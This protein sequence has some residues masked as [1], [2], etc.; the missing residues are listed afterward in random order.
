MLAKLSRFIRFG[1]ISPG[2]GIV[3][4]LVIDGF[5]QLIFHTIGLKTQ[6]RQIKTRE[7][8]LS[9]VGR[10]V[11]FYATNEELPHQIFN[12]ASVHST[13]QD[14]SSNKTQI[15]KQNVFR[16]LTWRKQHL[17]QC[18]LSSDQRI[19]SSPMEPPWRHSEPAPTHPNTVVCSD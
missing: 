2:N 7:N 4:S 11:R 3:I 15:P 12:E 17:H 5:S 13:T 19:S 16:S 10:K 18:L 8:I 14:C 1:I 6:L 9:G